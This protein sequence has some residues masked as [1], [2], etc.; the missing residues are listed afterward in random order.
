MLSI[1][2]M[3]WTILPWQP[4]VTFPFVSFPMRCLDRSRIDELKLSPMR[5][6]PRVH[7]GYVLA[8]IQGIKSNVSLIDKLY[9]T[10]SCTKLIVCGRL[11]L[12]MIVYEWIAD[13]YVILNFYEE[14]RRNGTC[15][16]ICFVY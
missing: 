7:C 4:F 9:C 6:K 3:I 10:G 1:F 11:S 15:I 16:V 8:P 14:S 5:I 2:K 13:F 12:F